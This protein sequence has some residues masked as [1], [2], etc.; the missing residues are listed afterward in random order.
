[1][2]MG[3]NIG[4]S[5]LINFNDYGNGTSDHSNYFRSYLMGSSDRMIHVAL[6]GDPTIRMHVVQ[7]P[8]AVSLTNNKLVVT[9]KWTA[10]TEPGL[11]GY[12]VYRSAGLD[13]PFI[14]ITS[15]IVTGT[16][17][18]DNS[19]LHHKNFYMVRA[20]KLEQ[21]A[22][23]SYFN[24]SQGSMDTLTTDNSGIEVAAQ[25]IKNINVFPNP[26]NSLFHIAWQGSETSQGI[27]KL[28]DILGHDLI[29]NPLSDLTNAHTIALDLSSYANGVYLIKITNGKDI[30]VQQVVK[31]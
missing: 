3:D 18:T 26:G 5:A 19:A 31:E 25:T 20:V 10:S 22:S 4:Y 30:Y 24:L 12:Y 7:P 2:A 11:L 1:M 16:T 15:S 27:M 14:N 13:Q 21:N 23:G 28:T 17:F 9:V 8:G 29:V 6:L